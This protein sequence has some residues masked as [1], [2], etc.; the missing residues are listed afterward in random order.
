MT[1]PRALKKMVLPVTALQEMQ[2]E[3]RSALLLLGLFLN[4]ANW[5]RKLLV[6]AVLGIS[7]TPE[8]QAN[9]ALTALLA[10]TLAGKIH[11]GWDRITAG[12]LHDALEGIDLPEALQ[13]LRKELTAA[14]SEKTFLRIRNNIAFHYPKR[15]LDFKKL[16]QHLEDSDAII[17]MAPEG[18]GGDVLSHLS[19]LAGIEPLL[20][21]NKDPDYRIA[22]QSVWNEVTHVTGIYCQFVSEVIASLILKF[23]PNISVEDVTIPDAPEADEGS[24]RFFVHP[25]DDLEEMRASLAGS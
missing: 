2:V 9:F 15:R 5:L 17:Y 12:P 20:A 23:I 25:P 18:Y 6:K 4:E 1:K 24:L 22:L 3:H 8:G 13:P 10:T 16:T 19:T 14:L 11:E 21:I 7:D